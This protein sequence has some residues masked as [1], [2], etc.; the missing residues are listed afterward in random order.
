MDI[1]NRYKPA[2][3]F[4]EIAE[5]VKRKDAWDILFERIQEKAEIGSFVLA[6][7]EEVEHIEFKEHRKDVA[8]KLESLGFKVLYH[9]V[10]NSD[11]LYNEGYHNRYVIE[12]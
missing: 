1:I 6:F 8:S 5:S 3:E 7:D 12:W 2:S 10:K 11:Y 4:H 9:R